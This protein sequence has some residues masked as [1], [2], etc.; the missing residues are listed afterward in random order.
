V[1]SFDLGT[2]ALIAVVAFL[3]AGALAPLETLGWWAGW[4]GDTVDPE[5]AI[6]E[7]ATDRARRA[8]DRASERDRDREHAR[9][10]VFLSGIHSVSHATHSTREERALEALREAV[11]DAAVVEVFPYSVTNRAL[12]G[13]RV[14]SAFWRWSLRNK[15]SRRRLRQLGGFLIN[16]RNLFQVGVSADRRYGPYYNRGT[17]QLIVQSLLRQ[18]YRLGSGA[19]V[20]LVGYS[21][22]GQVAVGAAPFVKEQTGGP[23]TVVSLG[24]VLAADPGLLEADR[25]FHL[26]GRRDD[27]QRLGALFFPGR[28]PLVSYSPWNQARQR[29]TLASVLIGPSDHTGSGGYLD[30]EARAADGRTYLQVTV[31]V[32]A[33][34]ARG[35]TEALPVA[36]AA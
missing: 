36:P 24:G 25:V 29:G 26:Y 12:T 5:E 34:I 27:V 6:A 30:D 19:P 11:P 17:A 28:W 7:A 16:L 4:Y 22:G 10:V 2:L 23:V 13:E 3:V 9:F 1:I 33:A 35:E 31:D 32:L 15:L 20:T 18:R 21:G 14:F 8:V